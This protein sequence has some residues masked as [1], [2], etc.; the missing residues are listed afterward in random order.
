MLKVVLQCLGTSLA[1]SFLKELIF[2]SWLQDEISADLGFHKA[3]VLSGLAFAVCHWY[4][5]NYFGT[6]PFIFHLHPVNKMI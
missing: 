2:R 6:G 3:T 5:Y 1:I 4:V